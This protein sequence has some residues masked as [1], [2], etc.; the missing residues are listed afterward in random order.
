MIQTQAFVLKTDPY[1]SSSSIVTFITEKSSISALCYSVKKSSKNIG[2]DLN[3]TAKINII[4]TGN[5]NNLHILKESSIIK[6]YIRLHNNLETSLVISYVKEVI[7][8]ISQGTIGN[9]CLTLTEKMFDAMLLYE[10]NGYDKLIAILMRAFE[11]KC[12]SICGI[13]PSF[14]KCFEC[15]QDKDDFWYYIFEANSI[16]CRNCFQ[17]DKRYQTLHSIKLDYQSIQILRILKHK[18]LMYISENIYNYKHYTKEVD[19]NISQITLTNIKDYIGHN[20]KSISVIESILSQ[21]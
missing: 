7:L 14:N 21:S 3:T 1:K 5:N 17:K 18:P 2:S 20:V 10:K 12:L 11:I 4:L 6:D 15:S 8:Y 13:V 16:I 9:E 19:K